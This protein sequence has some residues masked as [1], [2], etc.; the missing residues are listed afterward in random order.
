[1]RPE[2]P[3]GE[4]RPRGVAGR[5]CRRIGPMVVAF[6]GGADSAFLAW[7]A[8][9]T[10]GPTRSCAS[11]PSPRRWPPRSWTT[12]APWPPSGG[13]ATREV[14]TDELADPAYSANDG[15]ALLPLQVDADGRPGPLAA[16]RARAGRQAARRARR[17]PRRPGRPPT[18][19]AGGR[20]ARRPLPAGGGR[21]H[22]SRRPGQRPGS[23]AC[24]PGTSRPPPAWPPAS[25]TAP[26]SPSAPCGRWPRP[27]RACG[28]SASAS[29]GCATTATWPAS[30]SRPRTWPRWWP[31]GR[32]ERR[33]STGPATA[34]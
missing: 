7:V 28:P 1:M 15:I 27:S 17:Q 6:S 21:L 8:T 19:P 16:V 23:S 4:G 24:G 2:R 14:D 5:S 34:T 13:S 29:C 11:P 22:Q 3:D 9:D 25:L 30:R 10:L 18:R 31:P 12:A 32:G 26:R 33:P 20:R